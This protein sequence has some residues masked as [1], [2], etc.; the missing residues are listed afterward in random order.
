MSS[1]SASDTWRTAADVGAK[2]KHPTS[3]HQS[4]N[5]T[6]KEH[7]LGSLGYPRTKGYCKQKERTLRASVRIVGVFQGGPDAQ[8]VHI[9]QE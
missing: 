4:R 9:N 5:N 6:N 3:S 7:S 2:V 8:G 1:G